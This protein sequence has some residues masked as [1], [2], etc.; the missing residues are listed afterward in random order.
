MRLNPPQA[1]F[2][3]QPSRVY[4]IFGVST[5]FGGHHVASR[6]TYCPLWAYSVPQSARPGT[7]LGEDK[8][9][10]D[11]KDPEV[12]REGGQGKS[13]DPV[14]P[15]AFLRTIFLRGTKF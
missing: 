11:R 15:G 10:H 3:M 14:L 4:D 12:C 7:F 6:L 8:E 1:E 5:Y 13:P 9:R 2:L